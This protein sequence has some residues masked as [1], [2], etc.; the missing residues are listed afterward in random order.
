[1]QEGNM[2]GRNLPNK[3]EDKHLCFDNWICFLLFI[4]LFH[5]YM[6]IWRIDFIQWLLQ[7]IQGPGLLFSFVII[8]RRR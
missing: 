6:R 3:M 2:I 1:M 7:P 5:E 8:Y 4:H